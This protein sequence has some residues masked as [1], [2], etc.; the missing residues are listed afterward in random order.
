NSAGEE[1]I[2]RPAA[3][4]PSC[5]L[6]SRTLV[7]SRWCSRPTSGRRVSDSRRRLLPYAALI[8]LALIWGGSFLAIKVTVQDMSPTAL[9][10]FRSA[11]GCVALAVIVLALRKPLFG[12]GWRGRLIGFAIMAVT[13]AV[14]PWVSIGW[15][16]ERISSGLAS[17]LNSTTTLWTAVLIYWVV[18]TERPTFINY[19]GVLIGFAGVV[20]LVYPELAAHG[21][22]G[23]VLGALAVVLASLSYSVNALYQR[24]K[25]RN[26]SVYE[27]S[28]GQ[29]AVSVLFAIPLAAPSLPH[30]HFRLSSI[31]AVV[32]LGALGTG[33]AYLLYYYVMNT[34]GAVRAAGVTYVVPITAVFWGA[35]LLHEP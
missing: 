22:S 34:L 35:L 18:P 20:V 17:I 31:V 15:G 14:I 7:P 33:V 1:S 11:S 24:R 4:E 30:I 3:S 16:E 27:I 21:I 2:R 10:L 23:D 29:I 25:M 13:N 19:V 6:A 5:V 8:G 32:A 12:P 26:V 9:L 28:L